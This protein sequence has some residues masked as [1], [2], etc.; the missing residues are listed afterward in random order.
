MKTSVSKST[1]SESAAAIGNKAAEQ[2]QFSCQDI[3]NVSSDM[4]CV[5]GF[6][7]YLKM[8]NPSFR[9]TLLW[10]EKDL[11][12]TKLLNFI[13]PLDREKVEKNLDKIHGKNKTITFS[14]RFKK[15]NGEF[16]NLEWVLN[17]DFK[18]ES[19]YG[20]ARD[21]SS[22]EQT[23]NELFYEKALLEETNRV[24]QVGGWELDIKSNR[25]FWTSL[26]REIHEVDEDYKVELETAIDFYPEGE[27]RDRI[28]KL[29]DNAIQLNL[30]YDTEL[31]IITPSGKRK[32]VR[33]KGRPKF[34]DG[35]CEKLIGT[36]EDISKEKHDRKVLEQL[37]N[38][39]EAIMEASTETVIIATDLIGNVIYFNSGAERL[40]GYT[41]KE[42][43]GR[44]KPL[45]FHDKEELIEKA[46]ALSKEYGV[47][48]NPDM[49]CYTFKARKGL[50]DSQEYVFISRFGDRATVEV[51]ITPI[52]N[53]KAEI[54]GYLTIGVD[55][56]AKNERDKQILD[57][58]TRHRLF[59][60]NS[61]VVM[62]THDLEGNFIS[63]NSQGAYLLGY[64]VEELISKNIQDII[65]LKT[66]EEF[67]KYLKEIRET[68]KSKGLME[69]M[70]KTGH[71]KT[72]MFNNVLTES[73]DGSEYVIGNVMDLTDRIEL[74]KDLFNAKKAAEYN[75][76]MKDQFLANMSHEIR[77]PMNAITG[78]GKL[79][80]KT[81][82][83]DSIQRDYVN[84]IN[85][86]SSNLLNLINDILDFSKIESGQIT[87]ENVRFSLKDQINNV[88]KILT[89]EARKKGL[90]LK[91]MLDFGLPDMVV[92]DPTRLNQIL[93]NLMNNAIKFTEEGTVK[94]EVYML[95]ETDSVYNIQFEIEDTGI[96]I[97]K[98]KIEIIFDRFTQA[99]T[100]TT[101]KYGGTGL[102]LSISKSLVNLQGGEMTVTSE[103]GKGS[104]FT[105]TIPFE[106][107]LEE[108]FEVKE[109]YIEEIF[110]KQ[111]VKVLL[112]EDNFLNQKLA[113]KV[114][115]IQGFDAK[116]CENG[117]KAVELLQHECFDIILM[118]LQMPEMDG[119]T[120][121]EYIRKELKL[122]TPIMAMTAHSIVGEK[123]KCL[124]MGMDDYITKPF[125]PEHLFEK[126][127]K[128][129]RRKRNEN[130]TGLTSE[131]EIEKTEVKE[132]VR[133]YVDLSYL[134][135]TCEGD[136]DFEKE[137]IELSLKNIPQDLALILEGIKET[138]YRQMK[139]T[140][141]K[142]KSSFLAIG[143]NHEGI[144]DKLEYDGIEDYRTLESLY[145][146][147]ENIFE[148]SRKE[149][150]N[151]LI[152]NY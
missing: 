152:S 12:R 25:L 137:M 10:G 77:T 149:L 36:F 89:N 130:R 118:D 44:I 8:V 105:F 42:V 114:L 147:L 11:L 142:L 4:I 80:G 49:D 20:I 112:V 125:E 119:Y 102:G 143:I 6:D 9:R 43:V 126:I 23:K 128:L 38:H 151:I 68:G 67:P 122:D 104:K 52:K 57:S 92:G 32:W 115:E 117:R 93:V 3:F 113:L 75:A 84:S 50:T 62:Y 74:E 59:F 136:A 14:V 148:G 73:S 27:D 61:Q 139:E 34:V 83:L 108:D 129:V 100:N 39:L 91:C 28:T 51:S 41:A 150:E 82:N 140:A 79:L 71:L 87:I 101:R 106:K 76:Q 94:L 120:A 116:M 46:Q 86:A 85:L 47:E 64:E 24:A 22:V 19:I 144:L 123:D 18:K 103:E 127:N 90:L 97:S 72:W 96:G 48:V 141:H 145:F 138:N 124:S 54:T 95:E 111:D 53:K 16:L 26:T 135:S 15:K 2:P 146:Q 132:E 7:G 133:N 98:E 5:I 121:A 134:K 58:E 13:H 35:K 78:F 29:V 88:R 65:P 60:E 30:P 81:R 45:V 33:A 107:V 21:L 63:M 56:T 110:E 66:K 31:Q 37:H 40:L 70:D 55:V 69:I 131:K 17:A 1:V 109:D 99:N